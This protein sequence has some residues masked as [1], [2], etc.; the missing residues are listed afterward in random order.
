MHATFFALTERL[1]PKLAKGDLVGVEREVEKRMRRLPKSPFHIVLNLSISNDPLEA[2]AHFDRLC[3]AAGKEFKVAAAWTEMNEF[4]INPKRWYC[5]LVAASQDDYDEHADESVPWK[6]RAAP[7]DKIYCDFVA[8]LEKECRRLGIAGRES[9]DDYDENADRSVP[10]KTRAAPK[11]KIWG[12]EKLQKVYGS[13]AFDDE[14]YE[15][16]SSICSLLVVVK[17]QRFIKAATL[18]MNE[19][20]FP[21][22][23][24][25]HGF[26]FIARFPSRCQS[27]D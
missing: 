26:E 20:H 14:E 1:S 22:Y 24:T 18:H 23:A 10:W 3:K 11:Y 15:E 21:L 5:D 7:K 17:F 2:A 25:G 6:T 13:E 19:L 16:A 9:Q 12:L 27:Q 8:A 4:D